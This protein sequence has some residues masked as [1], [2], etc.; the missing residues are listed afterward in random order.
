MS[1]LLRLAARMLL[2]ALGYRSISRSIVE[3]HEGRI[4]A[5]GN[6]GPGATFRFTLP[7]AAPRAA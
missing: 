2:V 6:A 7:R 5:A 1:P 4:R 3:A